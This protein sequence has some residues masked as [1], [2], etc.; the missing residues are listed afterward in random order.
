MRDTCYRGDPSVP[1]RAPSS[2]APPSSARL[3]PV[4]APARPSVAAQQLGRG[5]VSVHA[6]CQ[7][8]GPLTVLAPPPSQRPPPLRLLQQLPPS[9]PP[10]PHL[11]PYG[12]SIPGPCSYI[13]RSS[14]AVLPGPAH[15]PLARPR[16]RSAAAAAAAALPDGSSGGAATSSTATTGSGSLQQQQQQQSGPAAAGPQPPPADY[17][18][19]AHW[20][21]QMAR[22]PLG[23]KRVLQRYYADV[24]AINNL[25]V[26]M[27]ALSNAQLRSKTV[28]FKR[29]L[30]EGASLLSLRVEAFAVVREAS[31]RVLGM[32]HYDCQLVGGMVLADGQVA[33]MQTGEGKTLV[34]T[35]PG[36]LGALTG[37]GVHVVTVNDYLAARDAAWM[38]KL[39]RFLGLTCAAVQSTSSVA[40][41]RAA[42][43]ADVTY[44][45]GQELGFS[46]LR[47]NTALSPQ[48]LM[49]RD[50]R[51]HF[52]IVDEVDSILIDESR[53]PM[54]I[55]GKGSSDTRVV[56]LVDKAV[57]RLWEHV[58][59]E[60]AAEV[61]ACGPDALSDTELQRLT[62]GVKSRYYTVDEKSRTLSYSSTG[63]HLIF[64]HLL[65][66]GAQFSD[67][68]P[69]VH[70]LWEE[71]V[72]WGRLAVT[73]LTAYELYINGRD[74]IVRDGEAVIV[75][76]STGRIRPQTR[77]QGGIHQAV[78][79]K[80]GLKVQAE[81][82]VT[83]TITFQLFFR[84]YEWLSGMTVNV[85]GI[86][87]AGT[88]QPAA[89]E[90]FEL[91]GI[92]VVPVPTNRP[93]R[94]KDH[95]PRLFY[96]KA[97]KMHC[98]A[99]EVMQAAEAQRPVLIGTT[100]VQESE[101]VLN[102]LMKTVYPSITAAAAR[103]SAAAALGRAAA[104]GA[105]G[106][107]G[108]G[109][110]GGLDGDGA[111]GGGG[112][113]FM[114]GP[115]PRITLLNAKPE[116]VR[117]EAQ[118]IAQAGL[119]GAV[120]IATNM[121][122]RGTDIILGGNPEGLTKLAL[123]RLV[124]RRLLKFLSTAILIS[125]AAKPPTA[126]ELASA[127]GN[128]GGSASFTSLSSSL[129]GS[130]GGSLDEPSGNGGSSFGGG[131]I[132]AT[133][134]SYG[135]TAELVAWVMDRAEVLRRK[136]RGALRRT[137]REHSGG[138]ERLNYTLCVAPVIESVLADRERELY[139]KHQAA[140]AAAAS[141]SS[142]A[143]MVRGAPAGPG[144]SFTD[145]DE[146]TAA[147]AVATAAAA[148]GKYDDGEEPVAQECARYR[149]EVRAAGGLLVIGTS[150]NESPR[151]ELQ[152][153]G[154]AG[155]QGDPGETKMLLDCVDPLMLMFGMDKVSAMLTQLGNQLQK[156]RSPSP[157]LRLLYV[158]PPHSTGPLPTRTNTLPL[159]GAGHCRS[160][161]CP[162]S[163]PRASAPLPY[164]LLYWIHLP[165]AR[166]IPSPSRRPPPSATD[167]SLARE[168]IAR[169]EAAGRDLSA[170]LAS[171]PHGCTL[172]SCTDDDLL[173]YLE[174]HWLPNRRVDDPSPNTVNNHLG[175]LS[176]L[177]NRLGRGSTYDRGTG[178]GN[179]CCS[180][181]LSSYKTGYS[182]LVADRG[183]EEQ[184][185]SGPDFLEGGPVDYFIN[186]VVRWQES[187]FQNMRLEPASHT[188]E[189]SWSPL[190][191]AS[192]CVRQTKKYDAVM[193]EYR[194]NLYTLRRLRYVDEL[195]GR[196]LD[197]GQ[198]PAR[199][200]RE[201][202]RLDALPGAPEQRP[203]QSPLLISPLQAVLLSL[204]TLVNPPGRTTKALV[205]FTQVTEAAA[206]N[207]TVRKML[208]LFGV[209]AGNSANG[210][211]GGDGGGAEMPYLP[212]YM[213]VQ[214]LEVLSPEQLRNLAEYIVGTGSLEWHVPA[215]REIRNNF[216]LQL[217]LRTHRRLFGYGAVAVL[218]NY[219][220]EVLIGCYE[221]RRLAARLAFTASPSL[222]FTDIDAEQQVCAFEQQ[223]ML[224]WMDALWGCF[225]EDTT[226]LRNAVNI[227]SSNGSNPAEEF[228]IEAN[229]AFLAL[230]DN[231][232]DAV[233]D[234]LLVPDFSIYAPLDLEADELADTDLV[235]TTLQEAAM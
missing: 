107:G 192:Y 53:N 1:H 129:A 148:G 111:G 143:G 200:L 185:A 203:G 131:E 177:F 146:A 217:Q 135:E 189:Y 132:A 151:I 194:H 156:R 166:S 153:R 60:I 223:T 181:A 126:E 227:R 103:R 4:R 44:V 63:T 65:D 81:N 16:A 46:Y 124:Y 33:E 134:I 113:G 34:A 133:G 109:A 145:D 205:D 106:S 8:T 42:F 165:A 228:R 83:A 234:K 230:L 191:C 190:Y 193:E 24:I 122:G 116:L 187:M 195:V 208:E 155:R 114:S 199:W 212:V 196:Y 100:T 219:L 184:A 96:D 163:W 19:P 179:P 206:A 117:L 95:P 127:G 149:E 158:T 57:R 23:R 47:D 141:S 58:Q 20:Q 59:S 218:R 7:D 22:A 43:A 50:D 66:E 213:Q 105:A 13:N 118:V 99:V 29:R 40:A 120:T 140:A 121:A 176:G 86:R 115:K 61:A 64:L 98:L 21:E 201:T 211:G 70:S 82:L 67:P 84:Q 91:Y 88:A 125:F 75:D 12:A 56:Q 202:V 78:E 76:P 48:D 210:A 169:Q 54:I 74:Y 37:R 128:G 220:G 14:T 123:T 36:Y 216:K 32:R 6:G 221:A 72:P 168:T 167:S 137:Y 222:G 182:R 69:G 93:S 5:D 231:Y 26:E 55:S 62:K 35:L 197:P 159:S 225:L 38:G 186:Y 174:A 229:A 49:L 154:R 161:L 77:W 138:L 85:Y 215:A 224:L 160:L 2:V 209:G 101:L 235:P 178:I 94:R 108:R 28:E 226:R 175:L 188:Q 9:L 144:S 15:H 198:A 3:Y 73:S 170:W 233:L 152:L 68:Y 52:A 172:L 27:R 142:T 207:P 11:P 17:Q 173:V 232:R 71:E 157:L 180:S 102:Y 171:L 31:R 10:H 45:T 150:L 183:Y 51:F 92:K 112:G 214:E 89:A 164:P 87:T 136:V 79:A 147:A 30:S 130:L 162:R 97:V 204:R 41:A 25:E 80:E 139:D 39:Y 18:L 90:L 119:P 110:F 104:F